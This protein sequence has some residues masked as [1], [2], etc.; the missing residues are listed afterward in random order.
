ML[1]F[2]LSELIYSEVA[3]NN[4]INNMPDVLS[5]DNILNLIFYC[6]QPARNLLAQPMIITS[7]YRCKKLNSLVGGV[8]NSAHLFGCAADFI[9]KNCSV[10]HVI[11][12]ISNSDIEFDQ[13]INE[14]DKWVHI[15]YAKN[16]NRRQI[17]KITK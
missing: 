4:N 14:Y 16:K 9:V 6:L 3:I 17:L 12:I 10:S 2:K 7:G 15:S 11:A 13:L 1:N 5:L 8:K